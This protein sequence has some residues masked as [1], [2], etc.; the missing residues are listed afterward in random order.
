M[1]RIIFVIL[2]VLLF[3][4]NAFAIGVLWDDPNEESVG[5]LGYKV[6]YAPENDPGATLVVDVLGYGNTQTT[7]DSSGF[8]YGENYIFKVTVYNA[9]GESLPAQATYT[10]PWPGGEPTA[11]AQPGGIQFTDDLGTPVTGL[12][13]VMP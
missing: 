6:Y 9:V 4:A 3:T 8:L 2:I 7:I 5:V 13:A 11:P 12:P 10:M 1:R